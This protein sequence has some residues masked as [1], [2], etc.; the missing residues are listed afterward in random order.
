M[1]GSAIRH[2]P[3]SI[4]LLPLFPEFYQIFQRAGW[5]TYFER[6]GEFDQQQ[7]L[8]FAQN[9]QGNYSVVQGVRISITEED[10]AQVSGLPVIG[11]CWFS[12]KQVILSAQ[13]DFLLPDEPV[14]LKGRGISL[15]SLPRPWPIV[16]EFIKHYLTCEGCYQVV[17]QHEFV[18][19]N[20]LRHEIGRAHV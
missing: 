13:Q 11:T 14:E 7:V 5:T 15:H 20:H 3:G 9:L 16:V 1:G 12:R 19:M 17:Y 10:I 4:T 8:E 6:L 18:L 2:E